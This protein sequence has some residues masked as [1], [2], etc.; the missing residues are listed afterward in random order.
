MAI[1][2][3]F[4]GVQ[5]W[6]IQLRAKPPHQEYKHCLWAGEPWPHAAILHSSLWEF[7]LI[8]GQLS[9]G[10][11]NLVPPFV[12]FKCPLLCIFINFLYIWFQPKYLCTHNSFFP[13]SL[14][15]AINSFFSTLTCINGDCFLSAAEWVTFSNILKK[16]GKILVQYINK[17]IPM[18]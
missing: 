11:H 13:W 3:C 2:Y 16:L 7:W 5:N 10:T 12:L 17:Y 6:S 4:V 18:K 8:A 9:V 1:S 15:I 14:Y